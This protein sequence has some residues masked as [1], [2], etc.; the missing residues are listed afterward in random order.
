[1]LKAK[2]TDCIKKMGFVKEDCDYVYRGKTDDGD[3]V[4]LF[5]I[6]AGSLY[7]RHAKTTYSSYLQLKCIYDWTKNN[8]IEWEE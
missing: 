7:L 3:L 8:Y 5:T 1:M 2:D 6:Y 4:K